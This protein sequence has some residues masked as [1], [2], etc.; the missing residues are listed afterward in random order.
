[1]RGWITALALTA[2][3]AAACEVALMLAVDIS[4]SV[5]ANEFRIQMEGLAAAL[6]DGAVMDALVA[7]Q[8][9]VALMQWSGFN[10]QMVAVNWTTTRT[11]EDVALLA[12]QI[13]TS[14]RIWPDF[15]TA[16][17]EAMALS[18]DYFEIVPECKRRVMDISGDGPNNEGRE[19]R[20]LWP[21][22]EA[23]NVTVN[24]L[25]I[26]ESVPNLTAYFRA[27]VITGPG[28]FAVTANTFDEYP[29][30]IRRKLYRELTTPIVD[31]AE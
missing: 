19:P 28:A 14:P 2:T 30:Q 1:M 13:R 10:R 23:A 31:L 16:I 22:L 5:N 20:A 17:G 8:S 3:P 4:G 6:E 25:V 27:N 24:A 26:E 11:P 12:E 18:L 29:E 15:S 9:E 21:A 7:G